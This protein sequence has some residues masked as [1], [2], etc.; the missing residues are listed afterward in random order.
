MTWG[1]WGRRIESDDKRMTFNP[2]RWIGAGT[3]ALGL[4][5]SAAAGAQDKGTVNPQPLP[6]LAHPD[7]PKT[8]ARELFGRKTEPAPMQAR[9]IGFYAKGCLAGGVALPINGKTW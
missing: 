5:L 2:S 7:D 9:T 8:P 3:L 4:V 6:P 1:R